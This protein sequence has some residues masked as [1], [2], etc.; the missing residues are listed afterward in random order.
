MPRRP[1]VIL[2]TLL[3]AVGLTSVIASSSAGAAACAAGSNPIVCENSQPGDTGWDVGGGG[4]PSIEGFAT[5]MSVNA[6]QTVSFKIRTMSLVNEEQQV[7]QNYSI[8]IYRLGW[9][10]GLG[11]RKMTPSPTPTLRMQPSCVTDANTGLVDCGTWGVSATWTVPSTAVSGVYEAHIQRTDAD[12]DNQIIFVV[13]N[14]TSHS[15]MLYQTSDTT[16]QAY[17]DWGGNSL[18]TG[19]PA[20]R[21]YMVSYNRPFS[22]RRNTPDGRDFLFGSEYPMI[23]FLERNGYD[24]SYISG[25]DTDRSGS[26]LLNHNTFLSV[27]HDEYWSGQQ[28]AN[29]E[30]ARNAGVN[31]AFFSGNEV[32]WKTRWQNSIDGSNTAYRTL[33]S[34]KETHAN[35][36]IDPLDTGN[37]GS[38]WTGTWRD[39]R[40]SPP[41]DGGKPENALTGTIW[42][43][44]CCSYPIQV[45][46][47]DGKMRLW[48]GTDVATKANLGQTS[49]LADETL[50]Y[51]WDE[52][53]DNGSRPAGQIRL[54]TTTQNVD[55][56]LVDFGSNVA[57]GTA[58]HSLTMYRAPS[59]ALV[60]G[61]GTVQ[62]SWGL[63]DYHDGDEVAVNKS[64]QQATVN[65][66]ADMG[67]QPGTLMSG[68]SAAAA[69]TDTTPPQTTI[70]A[71]AAGA[72]LRSGSAITVTGTA[73]D[74]GGQVGGIEVS[75]DGGT[76]WHPATGRASW[77]YAGS[78]PSAG[79]FT[80]MARATDDSLRTDP[81]PASVSVVGKCPCSLFADNAVPS[82]TTANDPRAINLGVRF[83]AD[84]SGF[85]TGVRFYKGAGNT[86]THVGALWTNTG[87]L[88]AQT[89]F[90]GETASGWQT[91]SFTP[92][93]A[94]TAGTTYVVSYYAPNGNFASD[95]GYFAL[96]GTDRAPLH[97]A[98]TTA[99][100]PNGVFEYGSFGFPTGSF[101][102]GNYWVDPVYDTI[103]PPDTIPPHATPAAP[104]NGS[105]SVPP[106]TTVKVAFDEQV[107]QSTVAIK[108]TDPSGGQVPGTISYD[109][110]AHTATFTPTA[111]L[112]A[113]TTY[114]ASVSGV[115]DV[116][117]NTM[118]APVTWTFKTQLAAATPGVCP[119]GVWDDTAVPATVTVNDGQAVELG[120]KFKADGSG[121]ITGVRFYKGPQNTGTHIG[122]LWSL[123]GT[124]LAT[125]T[126]SGES[127]SGWQTATFAT[128][129]AVTAG[130]VYVVSYHT[131]AG[132]YSAT[133][134]GLSSAVDS[135][136]LHALADGVNGGNAVYKYGANAFP[137]SGG[138]ANYWVDVVYL[139]APDT[140]PP[141]V[142]STAP[143]SGAHSVPAGA[144]VKAT[145]NE[146]MTASSI[147]LTLSSSAGNVTGTVAYDAASRTATFTPGAALAA[148]TTYTAR[149]TAAKDAAGNSMAA[150]YTWTFTTSGVAACPCT[151]FSDDATP[152]TPSSN[153][154][155]SVE[156]GVRFS[157]DTTG[158]ISGVRFYKGAGNTG[159]HTGTLWTATGTKLATG[160]FTGETASGWQQL[161]FANPVAVTAGTTYVASYHAPVGHYS[162]DQGY[163]ATAAEIN[164]PLTALATGTGG[165]NGVYSYGA[166][167][168]PSASY[169]STN[170]WVDAVFSP[171]QPSDATPPAVVSTSPDNGVTSVPAT[172]T[173]SVT[174]DEDVVGSSVSISLTPAG[175]AAVAGT[176]AYNAATRTATFTPT[177]ALESST[178]Y[179][180]RV[181]GAK[182]STGNT[183]PAAVTWSF[184]TAVG[185]TGSC[186]CTL[187][188]DSDTPQTASASD[189][190]ALE[191]GVRFSVDTDGFISGV[192]FYKGGGNTGVHFG[193]LWNSTGT[194]LASARFAG[195]STAGWQTV[196]FARPVAVTAGTT[197]VASYFAPNG[198]YSVTRGTFEFNGVDKAPLHAP[199][200]V[201]GA[202]NG[203]YMYGASSFPSNGNDTNYWVDAVYV[204][205]AGAADSTR[206]TVAAT[207]P[208]AAATGV[209]AT[210]APVAEF[211][212]PVVPGSIAFTLTGPGSTSVAGTISYNPITM[213][214]T[215]TPTAALAAATQY[216]ATVTATDP[217]G[218]TMAAAKVWSF[219]TG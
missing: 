165:G 117:G 163:F 65:L 196:S 78:V 21:A 210:V 131:D 185:A 106:T 214:A 180:G 5:A 142:Q 98:A 51:E 156:L 12:R 201:A 164:P 113:A 92:A 14:D 45:P 84:Q 11:G 212:E 48:R 194:L 7:L 190:S 174:F 86:G 105:S 88:V 136:P 60:F 102:G 111:A 74:V 22:T 42:T 39:P 52:D 55:A 89:T 67:A 58:T 187:F 188:A 203:V 191:L 95:A 155:N 216:T 17:N 76:S 46:A 195:E 167:A 145:F 139:P 47:A 193:H 79:A 152:A 123:T 112:A 178:V 120:M 151:I 93:P 182:D 8:D 161:T 119:C 91:A 184:T 18:Y 207:T 94:V 4:D 6:G 71:P 149:V 103:A 64:M 209:A 205:S 35:T 181:S 77:S 85:L 63:D 31:L 96:N 101:N 217:A 176:T 137:T 202:P 115:Q 28:R 121:T 29:V 126:F 215:F 172:A 213:T 143:I 168:F 59:G 166:A 33:V 62:W 171:N 24:V 179:T 53:L 61:A 141:T 219:T 186:P 211:S 128:P 140:T 43:V 20:N 169:Q 129:V 153:D 108:V 73:S 125:V 66:F 127:T 83:T 44:N 38:V 40:F 158:W 41:A 19:S 54:S 37:A 208:A 159:T 200:S 170:Y 68:L 69:S 134:G 27:G 183:M 82:S 147:Q 197:Y 124:K 146:T 157:T 138:G 162:A 9:Y 3:M 87:Q 116:A 177:T 118:T 75:L 80:I 34:Y 72:Q 100:N 204:A 97:A 81:T 114:T 144:K 109:S 132:F 57:P 70:T 150:V 16:W 175:G 30:A 122:T 192:R 104:L 206:P 13:R 107:Q 2:S 56:K 199:K 148:A 135:P 32:F 90:S 25:I 26:L 99:S 218:N 160:T 154:G 1:L 130:T 189:T 23:R 15:S 50:G 36:P 110:T 198:G 49:T 10:G 133:S 173:A